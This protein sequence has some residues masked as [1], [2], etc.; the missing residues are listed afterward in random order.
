MAVLQHFTDVLPAHG[1]LPQI[2]FATDV[3]AGAARIIPVT[4]GD[5]IELPVSQLTGEGVLEALEVLGAQG[6][7]GEV[8][9]LPLGD[10]LY[11]AV[12]LGDVDES[13]STETAV[14]R[15]MG[16]AAR[17]VKNIDHA[18]VT[19]DFGVRA[20]VEGILLGGY[21][22]AG[23]KKQ[24]QEEDAPSTATRITVIGREEERAVFDEAVTICHA[25]A[26][27][28]DLV[29]TP[30]N[31]LY[32]ANYAELAKNV[33][34]AVGLSVEV[35]DEKELKDKG[36]GGITAVGQGSQRPPR[37]VHLSWAPE[38]ATTSVALVGKGITFDTGGISLKPASGMEQMVMDMGGSAAVLAASCAVAALELPVRVDAWLAMAENMPSGSA[39]R[40][41]DVIT[42]YGGI[43][44]EV[45]NTDAEGR[46]VLAD[47][48]ARA[49]EDNPTYLIETSTLTGAQM[50]A[51]GKRTFGVMGTEQLRDDIAATARDLDEPGW[52]MPMLEEHEEEIKSPVADVKNAN[53]DR[54]GGMEFAATYLSK[55]VADGIQW[56]H[57]DVASPAW[58]TGSAYGFT[59]ARATGVPVRTIVDTLARLCSE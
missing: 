28:R 51:L 17:A 50:V 10:E 29:N 12:G 58:N 44:S 55:F 42:H 38:K 21:S 32:P 4:S 1:Q 40:P 26:L 53:S 6:K 36:F 48:I 8:T 9:K 19:A 14:R 2:E 20:V 5:G 52:A 24:E 7:A 45:I 59:P 30:S 15:A 56:A 16:V 23:L 47:A 54:F 34:E 18:V 43:S 25:V 41:G 49:S 22:Y 11:I 46:L 13:D 35:L 57:V 27:A 39:Q 3:P 31:L 33:G 37:L